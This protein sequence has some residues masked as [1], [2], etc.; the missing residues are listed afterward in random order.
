MWCSTMERQETS[1]MK[2]LDGTSGR[3]RATGAPHRVSHLGGAGRLGLCLA[4]LLVVAMVALGRAP[5]AH[6][7]GS[8]NYAFEYYAGAY[9]S[10]N[11]A[12]LTAN[13]SQHVPAL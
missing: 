9:Q 6:A 13:L 3:A 12:G 8:G 2:E 7:S 10:Y 1:N 4:A 11:G 5:S